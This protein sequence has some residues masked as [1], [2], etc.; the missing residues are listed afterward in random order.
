MQVWE[1]IAQL[2][3]KVIESQNVFLEV[4]INEEGISIQLLPLSTYED[5]EG[6]DEDE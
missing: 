1:I 3:Q 4:L 2:S 5:Y 6:E